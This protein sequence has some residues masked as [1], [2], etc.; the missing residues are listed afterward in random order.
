MDVG[1]TASFRWF[2]MV[3]DTI[4]IALPLIYN[5]QFTII[6]I[7]P[8]QSAVPSQVVAWW[9][10][11]TL[12]SAFLFTFLPIYRHGHCIEDR[13]AA[14][15]CWDA[16][17]IAS[18]ILPTNGH[19][20]E[21]HYLATVVVQ[22]LISRSLSS[23]GSKCHNMYHPLNTLKLNSAHTVYLSSVWFSQ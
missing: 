16:Y 14:R 3:N 7:E 6:C 23:N 17:I 20:L 4:N 8:S 13:S 15:V 10:I 22:L 21:S 5:L 11:S 2:L 9:R 19:C 1:S 12:S 18:Q